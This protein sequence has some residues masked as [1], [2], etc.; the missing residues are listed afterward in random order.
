MLSGTEHVGTGSFKIVQEP[1][2]RSGLS[3][4]VTT[5]PTM[6]RSVYARDLQH[7]KL[8]D[9]FSFDRSQ[10]GD[11]LTTR[12]HTHANTQAAGEQ[13]TQLTPG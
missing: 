7:L 1:R 5:V 8:S 10:F 4:S 6:H 13:E 3:L 12:L 11:K 2:R 9:T